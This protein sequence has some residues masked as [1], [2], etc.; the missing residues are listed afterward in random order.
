[1]GLKSLFSL[2]PVDRASHLPARQVQKGARPARVSM[3]GQGIGGSESLSHHPPIDRASRAQDFAM[4]SLADVSKLRR[5]PVCNRPVSG[6][7]PGGLGRPAVHC[8][9]ICRRLAAKQAQ[10]GRASVRWAQKL[11]GLSSAAQAAMR[12]AWGP[13]QFEQRRQVARHV[14]AAAD[15]LSLPTTKGTR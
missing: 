5:C 2:P 3:Q 9:D 11:L 14:L 7:N 1:M 8:G 10:R 15:A 13:T 4:N 6:R 12:A